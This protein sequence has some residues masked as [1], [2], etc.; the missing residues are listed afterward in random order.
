MFTGWVLIL[1]AT[2]YGQSW[3]ILNGQLVT[4]IVLASFMWILTTS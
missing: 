3:M 2:L 1:E 4:L